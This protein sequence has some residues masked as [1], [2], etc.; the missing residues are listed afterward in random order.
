MAI[1]AERWAILEARLRA[2]EDKEAVLHTLH[3][4][5]RA[6]D[7]GRD[8]DAWVDLFTDD[9][10]WKGTPIT[11]TA[12]SGI[13]RVE[14]RAALGEWYLRGGRGGPEYWGLGF[15]QTH[16][17]VAVIDVR[18]DGDRADVWS[19]MTITHENPRGP[20]VAAL[21]RYTDVLVRCSDGR[22]RFR[23]RHLERT[24]AE[25]RNQGR[26]METPTPAGM[27]AMREV[28][29]AEVAAAKAERR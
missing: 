17:N 23:L 2:L 27:Q 9:G 13:V 12:G 16:H 24:C 21:G 14:G 26:P 28:F 15:R 22:W 25:P 6:M 18:I 7:F 8:V 4:Y 19:Y 29:L 1:S 5:A 3:A 10:V 20:L 11:S